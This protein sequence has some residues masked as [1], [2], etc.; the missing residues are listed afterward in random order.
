M[1]RISITMKE[2]DEALHK[3]VTFKRQNDELLENT[4][5]LEDQVSNQKKRSRGLEEQLKKFEMKIS[6]NDSQ[7]ASQVNKLCIIDP[8]MLFL[9]RSK[10]KEKVG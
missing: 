3:V 7:L 8:T 2:R 4:V 10:K 9:K 6:Q 1:E 5:H